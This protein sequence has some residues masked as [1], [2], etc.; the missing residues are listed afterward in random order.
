MTTGFINTARYPKNGFDTQWKVATQGP[1]PRP[2][3]M[4]DTRFKGTTGMFDA[5]GN[6]TG[7]YYQT[8]SIRPTWSATQRGRLPKF[9]NVSYSDYYSRATGTLVHEGSG[10]KFTVSWWEYQINTPGTYWTVFGLQ[11]TTAPHCLFFRSTSGSY[12]NFICNSGSPGPR[13]TTIPSPSDE[14]NQW[15]HWCVRGTNG[16]DSSTLADW[17]LFRNGVKHTPTTTVTIT[18]SNY[19]TIVGWGGSDSRFLG[20]LD[21]LTVWS[22][23]GLSDTQIQSIYKSQSDGGPGIVGQSTRGQY[24]FPEASGGTITGN[25]RY[26]VPGMTDKPIFGR[27]W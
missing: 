10:N 22:N 20:Y 17:A 5:T 25:R 16:C 3:W 21:Q 7:L 12:G 6:Y 15:I 1:L 27:G 26:G 9:G 11:T 4:M 19:N 18:W 2:D 23:V 14:S 13:F 24:Y 8:A